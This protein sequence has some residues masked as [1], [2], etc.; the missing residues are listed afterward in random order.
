METNQTFLILDGNALLHRAWHAIPPLTTKDGLVVNAAYGFTM[1]IEKMLEKFKPEFMAVAWD[2]PGK[3]FRHELFSDYKGHREKK[4]QELYNQIPIIQELLLAYGIPSISAKGFEADDVIATLSDKATEKGI[5]TLVVTGDLDSLQLVDDTTHVVAFVKGISETHIYDVAAVKERFALTPMELIDYKALRGDPSD[6][7]PGVQGVGEKTAAD[8]IQ[9]FGSLEGIFKAL[10]AGEIEEKFAKKL[11]GQKQQALD[12]RV[13]VK[14]VHD[15][16]INFS[17]EKSIVKEPNRKELLERFRELEFRTLIRK[18]EGSRILEKV[19]PPPPLLKQEI[20]AHISRNANELENEEFGNTIAV[21]LV[22]QQ[23]DLFGATLAAV[24]LSDGIKTFVISNPTQAHLQI[25]EQKLNSVS[26]VVTHD[27]KALMHQ[28]AWVLNNVFDTMIASYLLIAGTREHDLTSVLYSHLN[29]KIADIPET[30]TTEK[31]YQKLGHLVSML[32]ELAQKLRKEMENIHVDKVFDEIEMPL[33]PILFQME[34]AGIQL[35]TKSLEEVSKKLSKRIVELESEIIRFAR[36]E[37]NVNSPIQLAE[38]LFYELKLPTKGIK[39]TKTGF[40]TAASELEKLWEEHKIIPL[41]SENRELTKLMSTYVEALPKLVDKNGRVHTT[42]NQAVA[43]TGRLSSSD[44]NLQNIP[45]KTELGREIRKAFIAPKGKIIIAADYSQIE[46]RIIAVLSKD[47]PFIDAFND[48]A[49]IHTRTAAEIWEVSE[50][51]VTKDQRRAAKAINFGIMYGMGPKSLAR[52]AGISLGE[53]REFIDR[54]FQ[55]H[56]SVR[57]LF[58]EMKVKAHEDGFVET[59]FGR[60]RY[61][62][63][64]NSGV[65]MLVAQ[66]ERMAIN[67]PIQ[68]T[69]AD[70]VKKA[71]IEVGG[72]LKQSKLPASML[73]QVHD[74]LVFECV[75]GSVNE[76]VSGIQK[77]M[78]SVVSFEVPLLVDVEVGKNWGE[79]EDFK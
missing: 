14:L 60:R 44:P 16:Q 53:A 72:W 71:M 62:P 43:A 10:D 32:P 76:V 35:D 73:M 23:A 4:E 11:R 26:L 37:F 65:P 15:V 67:M 19:I 58:D 54:Y 74:E 6:N 77:I 51:I 79:M 28:T 30:F 27:A 24:G 36:H 39:K 13:L 61:L 59:L 3:T 40:S 63:E 66:A 12:S 2:L 64:I 8:L 68:G 29:K 33:V 75:N 41:I 50:D 47:R 42:Y 78:A 38:I 31:D 49:D 21:I 52:S 18:Y 34:S 48:G 55:I 25:I 57:D 70:I 46:L 17:F 22:T 5:L 9:R 69:Q 7:I 56:H 1:I 20:S 45:V